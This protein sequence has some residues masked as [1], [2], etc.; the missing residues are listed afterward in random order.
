MK[1]TKQYFPVVLFIM[2]Y[3]VALNFKSVVEILKLAIHRKLLSSSFFHGV[4]GDLWFM[5]F[6]TPKFDVLPCKIAPIS[7]PVLTRKEQKNIKD[8]K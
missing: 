8:M 5:I 4:H 7:Y 6:C 1:A 3:E 2:L